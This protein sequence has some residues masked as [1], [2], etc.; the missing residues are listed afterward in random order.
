MMRPARR[1]LRKLGYF[2]ATPR[3]IHGHFGPRVCG[4]GVGR[5][6]RNGGGSAQTIT[7]RI[8]ETMVTIVFYRVAKCWECGK[9]G[10]VMP[11]G[12]CLSCMGK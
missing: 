4:G 7:L 1:A 2:G 12:L 8:R 6:G 3:R 10:P 5:R 9:V 11:D